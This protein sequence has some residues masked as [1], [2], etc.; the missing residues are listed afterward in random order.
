VRRPVRQ[1]RGSGDR[2]LDARAEAHGTVFHLFEEIGFAADT[3]E[4]EVFH[5]TRG[6]FAICGCR[7][8]YVEYIDPPLPEVME[9]LAAL[10]IRAMV[11]HGGPFIGSYGFSV[12]RGL[13][14]EV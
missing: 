8:R 1:N 2:S 3:T 5:A 12:F 11:H 7:P 9:R 10:W 13:L 14:T 6:S 4:P